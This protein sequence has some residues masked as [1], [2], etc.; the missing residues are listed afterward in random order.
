MTRREG[1]LVN[2]V[3]DRMFSDTLRNSHVWH[4]TTSTLG[5]ALNKDQQKQAEICIFLSRTERNIYRERWQSA[6][7]PD[8]VFTKNQDFRVT[9]LTRLP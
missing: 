1:L 8:F 3:M 6:K 5:Y 7:W 2:D 9:T 4:S